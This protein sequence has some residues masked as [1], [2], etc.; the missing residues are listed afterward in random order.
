MAAVQLGVNLDGGTLADGLRILARLAEE[1]GAAFAD[2]ATDLE[3]LDDDERYSHVEV[4]TVALPAVSPDC[5]A[6]KC[7]ACTGDAWDT[8]KDRLTDC[9]HDCH[10][11]G[12]GLG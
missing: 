3:L 9:Q 11:Q 6:G 4:E 5:A 2:A 7:P 12:A 8:G 10:H 1:I